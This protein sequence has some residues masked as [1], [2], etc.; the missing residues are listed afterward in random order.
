[1]I[2]VSKNIGNTIF[3][4]VTFITFALG[5]IATFV[6]SIYLFL[7]KEWFKGLISLVVFGVTMLIIV[8][9][10]SITLSRNR[11]FEKDDFAE[12]LKIPTNIKIDNPI[13][14][15]LADSITNQNVIKIDLQ[16]YNGLQAGIYT[17]DFWINKIESGTIYLKALEITKGYTLSTSRL[18]ETNTVK[19]SNPTDTFKKLVQVLILLFM[20]EIG[21]NL[22]QQDLKFGSSQVM[23]GETGSYFQKIIKRK[24]GCDKKIV[25]RN[26]LK[27]VG[28]LPLRFLA[29]CPFPTQITYSIL[30]F[31]LLLFICF[32]I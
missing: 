15:E 29:T 30:Q 20:R 26:I 23:E 21:D 5:L 32:Y 14:F 27:T 16:L 25:V 7:K 13:D 8:T 28:T 3:A 1:M 12:N 6:S 2:V 31:T 19:I 9:L 4:S 22:M 10:L 18:A 17:F 24:D 11:R